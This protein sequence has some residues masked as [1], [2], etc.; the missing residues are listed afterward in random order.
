M[1]GVFVEVGNRLCSFVD[2]CFCLARLRGF[3]FSLSLAGL[4]RIGFSKTVMCFHALC[5]VIFIGEVRRPAKSEAASC[6]TRILVAHI[7]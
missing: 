4:P 5:H 6:K 7:C 1:F 2:C 3:L